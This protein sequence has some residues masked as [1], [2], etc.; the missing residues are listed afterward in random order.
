[1][2]KLEIIKILNT[3][4]KAIVRALVVL[5]ERQTASE[6]LSGATINQNGQGFTPADAYMGTSMAN[7]IAKW[8]SLTEKQLA[9]WKKPNAKGIPRINKYAGQLLTIAKEK[10]VLAIANMEKELA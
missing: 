6:Q 7:G 3:N 9:Y 5:N 2:T 1:M 4:D 8:G 10:A